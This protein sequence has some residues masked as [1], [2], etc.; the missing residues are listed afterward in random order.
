MNTLEPDRDQ[1]EIFV[2]A[3]LRYRGT[4]GFL[5]LRSFYD[6]GD[7]NKPAKRIT[8]RLAQG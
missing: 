6:D 4:E 7:P 2:D 5:S 3:I 1:L 8:P